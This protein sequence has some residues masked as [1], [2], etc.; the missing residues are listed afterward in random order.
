MA[1]L[2][3]LRRPPQV[4]ELGTGAVVYAA[5]VALAAPASAELLLPLAAAVPI[6]ERLTGARRVTTLI[7]VYHM[8][9][10]LWAVAG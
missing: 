10:A 3:L 2:A 1:T 9:G 4:F 5:L 7:C 6:H 8:L